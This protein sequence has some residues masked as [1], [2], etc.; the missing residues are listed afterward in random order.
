MLNYFVNANDRSNEKNI[1]KMLSI[2]SVQ[3]HLESTTGSRNADIYLMF[4]Q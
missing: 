1:Y 3:F 4:C 2:F